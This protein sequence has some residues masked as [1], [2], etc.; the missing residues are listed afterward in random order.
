MT[1]SVVDPA[2]FVSGASAVLAGIALLL[3]VSTRRFAKGSAL[4]SLLRPVLEEARTALG[5]VVAV[6]VVESHEI[7]RRTGALTSRLQELEPGIVD[8]SLRGDI[9][10][11]QASLAEVFARAPGHGQGH[12]NQLGG[13]SQSEAARVGEE[14]AIKALQRLSVLQMKAG[15]GR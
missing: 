6:G 12:S 3:S 15:V 11:L 9:A 4:A 2:L 10:S 7:I 5:T 8:E 1:E 14:R 13:L